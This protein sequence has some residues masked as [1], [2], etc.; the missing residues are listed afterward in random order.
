TSHNLTH[1]GMV[2]ALILMVFFMFINYWS[3][4]LFIRFNNFFTVIKVVIP[5]LT[6]GALAYSGL[7]MENFGHS[8]P[9]FMPNGFSSVFVSVV[10]CG[11]VMSF[12]GF[13]SPLNFSEEISNPKRMLPIAV[14][15]SILL[16]FV[17]YM[18]LQAV[19]IG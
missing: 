5:L 4:Q 8:L 10:A 9:E 6:I 11:V 18:L 2:F 3:V 14:V 16:A 19:F 1:G 15:S 7:H 12:N 13:Q 17:V